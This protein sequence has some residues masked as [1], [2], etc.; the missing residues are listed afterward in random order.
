MLLL[1]SAT[2][3]L[4]TERPPAILYPRVSRVARVHT[5]SRTPSYWSTR[6]G[7]R[8]SQQGKCVSEVNTSLLVPDRSSR[9]AKSA[10]SVASPAAPRSISPDPC[11]GAKSHQGT[12]FLKPFFF[13]L[14][15]SFWLAPSVPF[16]VTSCAVAPS[17]LVAS[18]ALLA[19][20][21]VSFFFAV[22]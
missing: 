3:I 9:A 18:V 19:A 11:S 4:A 2:R 22:V 7:A 21:G 6:W 8:Q 10:R 14:V 5:E 17:A 1:S 12:I 15:D 13:L 20:A 16:C